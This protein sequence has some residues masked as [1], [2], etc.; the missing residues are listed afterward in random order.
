MNLS[1]LSVT[2]LVLTIS[3]YSAINSRTGIQDNSSVYL[4]W[5]TLSDT[6]K[7]SATY[8]QL[9]STNAPTDETIGKDILN[10]QNEKRSK[11][12]KLTNKQELALFRLV[13]DAANFSEGDCGTF[14]LNAGFIIYQG[15]KSIGEINIGCGYNQ[16]GVIQN[17]A[18]LLQSG[19]RTCV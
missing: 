14:Q 2:S 4:D 1:I 6:T 16:W 9:N 15:N 3:C 7:Y 8:I 17:Y 10:F 19:N 18:A 12:R 11:K 13:T 5:R